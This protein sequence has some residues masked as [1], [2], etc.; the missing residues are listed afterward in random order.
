M[1]RKGADLK[2]SNTFGSISSVHSGTKT[3]QLNTN[4]KM[5][6]FELIWYSKLGRLRIAPAFFLPWHWVFF[7]REEQMDALNWGSK[8]LFPTHHTPAFFSWHWNFLCPQSPDFT[9]LT[10]LTRT[11]WRLWKIAST[12]RGPSIPIGNPTSC[13]KNSPS[14]PIAQP[15]AKCEVVNKT[16][17]DS[18]KG[19]LPAINCL[20]P[21]G[22]EKIH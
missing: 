15:K 16:Q 10:L 22:K 11:F 6:L 20:H 1:C 4:G 7:W 12:H 8:E 13:G 5:W 14:P 3:K 17:I 2:H 9:V 19:K 18:P 21:S